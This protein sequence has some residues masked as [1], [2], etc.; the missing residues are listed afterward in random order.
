MIY[1]IFTIFKDYMQM[2]RHET[3]TNTKTPSRRYPQKIK[4]HS[5]SRV[6]TSSPNK[7]RNTPPSQMNREETDAQPFH[8]TM[9]VLAF[10]IVLKHLKFG[11]NPS[12]R[13]NQLPSTTVIEFVP[14]P[15][16]V[17]VALAKSRQSKSPN[18]VPSPL[19]K[20]LKY[21]GMDP[22]TF[23]SAGP[24]LVQLCG[25]QTRTKA[26]MAQY[27]GRAPVRNCKIICHQAGEWVVHF[28][29]AG[30]NCLSPAERKSGDGAGEG[31]GKSLQ[32]Q[33]QFIY[34]PTKRSGFVVAHVLA[35]ARGTLIGLPM[36]QPMRLS[37][38]DH[39]VLRDSRRTSS[40]AMYYFNLAQQWFQTS[41]IV[42]HGFVSLLIVKFL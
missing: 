21:N 16:T 17:S 42:L 18:N 37:A 14:F 26:T 34:V 2:E 10:F 31:G 28:L 19:M 15:N 8:S 25:C 3:R 9:A 30:V 13:Q 6:A 35:D 1:C 23:R 38:G 7:S 39:I 36:L 27:S 11:K 20:R 24:F 40:C 33:A 41:A 32:G 5:F 22:I 4:Q 12:M 29:R